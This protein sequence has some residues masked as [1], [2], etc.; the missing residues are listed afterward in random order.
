MKLDPEHIKTAVC[1]TLIMGCSVNLLQRKLKVSHE[2]ATAL[3]KHLP[4]VLDEY[5]IARNK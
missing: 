2:Y 5:I 4:N 3:M 1:L